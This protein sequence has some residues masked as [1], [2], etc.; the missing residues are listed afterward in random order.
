MQNKPNFKT[1]VR[2]QKTEDSKIRAKSTPKLHFSPPTNFFY[3]CR[4]PSTNQLLFMQ[5]KPNF[6]IG[7]MNVTYLIKV[8][9]ENIANSKLRQNKPNTNP[10][11]PNFLRG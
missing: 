7:K 10:I 8:D 6:K 4:E 1:E 9:Y 5:N 2:K 3:N 11:K